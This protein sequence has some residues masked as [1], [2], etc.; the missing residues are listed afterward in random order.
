[1]DLG[2]VQESLDA[3]EAWRRRKTRY[4]DIDKGVSTLFDELR[5]VQMNRQEPEVGGE[6]P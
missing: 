6:L 2:A 4:G 1:M 3:A 5:C